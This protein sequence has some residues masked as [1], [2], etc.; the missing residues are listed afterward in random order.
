M[1]TSLRHHW[2]LIAFAV[3][4]FVLIAP[5]QARAAFQWTTTASTTV[6]T[7]TLSPAGNP[8]LNATCPGILTTTTV[9]LS[10]TV[11]PSTYATGYVITPVLNG[12]PQTPVSVNGQATNSQAMT[13][14]RGIGTS[15]SYTF[16]IQAVYQNW[17]SSI[18]TSP[19][20]SC[21]LVVGGI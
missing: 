6:G 14:I 18:V 13:V 4:A 5:I 1:I 19:A 17:T 20:G 8:T 10:W 9:T 2:L 21:P 16:R 11:T 7:G 12:T 3:I 15:N